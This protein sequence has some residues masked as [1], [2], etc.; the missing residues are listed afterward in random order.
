MPNL[1][2]DKLRAI[3]LETQGSEPKTITFHG[4]TYE[5]PA[6]L[7]MD[8]GEL[9]AVGKNHEAIT[10][11]LGDERAE[12]FWKDK[13]SLPDVEA[14]FKGLD[15]LYGISGEGSG[16]SGGSSSATSKPSKRTSNATTA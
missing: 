4:E 16:V 14:F 7:S 13:P 9:L 1:D 3:R 11:L 15:G 12:R 5:L 10:E 8:F 6:E 2:L